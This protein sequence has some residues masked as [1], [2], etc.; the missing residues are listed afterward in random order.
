[1]RPRPEVDARAITWR[2]FRGDDFWRAIP[3]WREVDRATFEDPRWQEKHAV[4]S[5]AGLIDLFRGDLDPALCRDLQAGL[6]RSPMSL[7]ASPYIVSLIDWSEPRTDPLRLQFFPIRSQ[8]EEDH[9]LVGLDAV[10]E[11]ED[12]P[13]P[14]LTHRYFDRALFLTTDKCPVYCR[15]CTR[16]Y[17]VGLDTD[18]VTKLPFP[19][20]P[21]RWEKVFEHLAARIEIE[22]IVI[23][24]GDTYRLRPAQLRL[25]GERLLAIPHIRRLRFATKGLAVLPMKIVRDHE[26]TDALSSVADLARRMHKEV[27]IHTHFNHP[28]EMTSFTQAALEL[29]HQRAIL[30][31][32]LSVVLAGV[33]DDAETQIELARRLS[34]LNVRPYYAYIGDMVRGTEDLRT[35]VHETMQLEKA[36]RGATSGHN[37]PSFVLDAPG[38]GGKRNLFSFEHYDRETGISVYSA[39][40]V[41]PGQLFVYADPLRY[42]AETVRRRWRDPSARGEMV[43]AAIATA[44]ANQTADAARP[45]YRPDS[46]HESSKEYSDAVPADRRHSSAGPL[47]DR[48]ARSISVRRGDRALAQIGTADPDRLP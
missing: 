15:F 41:K 16:S 23:S 13:V 43:A 40:A 32:N 24:G 27:G 30:V 46:D 22:D 35:S 11:Q 3:A 39:P 36:V 12:S 45:T 34:Y 26:W 19:A 44:R 14:G 5:V 17:A 37:T 38:G 33:N 18:S 10:A 21:A 28:N 9:P 47:G 29:L 8:I 6:E 31:R 2:T 20:D 48:L 4:V 7:R 25:I 42:L 1:V